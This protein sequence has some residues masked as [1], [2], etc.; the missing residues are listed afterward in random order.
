MKHPIAAFLALAAL[1]TALSPL[2]THADGPG[3]IGN[4]GPTGIEIDVKNDGLVHVT[5]VQPGSPADGLIEPGQIIERVHGVKMPDQLWEQLELLGG[6]ITAAETLDGTIRLAVRQDQGQPREV[7]LQIPVLGPYAENPPIKCPKTS[8]IIAANAAWLRAQAADEAGLRRLSQH[9]HTNGMAILSLLSTGTDEDLAVVRAIYAERMKD[10]KQTDT[11]PH[12]WHNGWQGMAA[13]EY[14]LRTG[15]NSV[16][17]LINAICESARKYQV[18]GGWTHWATGVNPQYVGGGLLNAAGT[19]ILTTLLLAKMCGA[20]VNDNTLQSALR[21]YY[22]FA[23]HGA[24]AYG[25]HRPEAGYGGVNGKDQQLAA[26]MQIASRATNGEVYAM[27]RDKTALSTLHSYRSML[28]GHTGP[29]GASW[30]AP[31]ASYLMEEMPDHFHT[32]REQTRWFHELSRRHDGAFVKAA[33]ARY[34]NT[35]YGAFM[36]VGLTAPMRT[37]QITGAPPSPHAVAFELPA[38]PWGREADLAFFSLKGGPDYQKLPYQ[39]PHLEMATIA[40]AGRDQLAVF[41]QHPEH[42]FRETV[43]ARIR[44]GGHYD[45]IEQLLESPD[46]LARH[47]GCMAINFFQPWRVTAS[48]GWIS[49]A[50]IPKENFTP[51]MFDAL[52]KMAR[53]P[54]EALWLVDQA[55]IAMALAKPEQSL[56]HI[57]ALLPWLRQSDEWWLQESAAIGLSPALY[58]RD[59]LDRILPEMIKSLA[60]STHTKGRGYIEWMLTRTAAAVDPEMKSRIAAALKT[61]YAETPSQP[62]PAKPG[63]MDLTGISSVHLQSTMQWALT[64]DPTLAADLAKLSANRFENDLR[65]REISLKAR[66]LM[67][68]AAKLDPSQRAAVGQVLE[69]YYQSFIIEENREALSRGA[70]GNPRQFSAPLQMILD[71]QSMTG[72]GEGWQMLGKDTDGNQTW[73]IASFD[74]GTDGRP[75]N[76]AQQRFRNVGIPA[77][78]SGWNLPDFKPAPDQWKTITAPAGAATPNDFQRAPRAVR[79]AFRDADEVILL[80][81]EFDLADIDYE[82]FRLIVF[83]RQGFV[84]HINGEH[85]AED[86]SRSRTWQGR[87]IYLD[88]KARSHLKPG[89]NVITALSFMQYFR[90]KDGGLDL[91]LEGLRQFPRI[92]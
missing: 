60:P 84:V 63:D 91:Y 44:A 34:N 22:R 69:R 26:A 11:G 6:I 38:R 81:K 40:R 10:F 57:D 79:D 59:G 35:E 3:T 85:V 47:T 87:D 39:P 12:S 64:V 51:R 73:H 33:C 24:N 82:L 14:H 21:F 43:A 48:P 19:N 17:P 86:R 16:M 68:A 90:G 61:L 45:L 20:D 37:L 41:A 7:E 36:L 25:D 80:R 52:L 74:P 89:R 28:G 72:K 31:V 23:G 54:D 65:P 92:D 5:A 75:D 30:H 4:F 88:E 29:I 46:P 27:A 76:N 58:L 2:H 13:C 83:S 18:N 9:R 66:Q 77:E 15:D 71:I 8:K 67:D 1:L 62:R 50:A 32:R 56:P 55:M 42:V 78:F 53:D 70:K 49:S